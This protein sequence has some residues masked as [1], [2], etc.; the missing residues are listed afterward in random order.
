MRAEGCAVDRRVYADVLW[1]CEREAAEVSE[2]ILGH[3]AA[4]GVA[5]DSAIY[6]VLVN[7]C[8]EWP[9]VEK[10]RLSLPPSYLRSPLRSP[11]PLVLN[12]LK[13]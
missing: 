2:D 3:M 7:G 12:R 10:V 13:V 1:A 11:G 6:N 5:P 8:A 4:A 9:K